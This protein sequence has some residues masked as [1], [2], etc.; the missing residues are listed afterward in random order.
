MA[1]SHAP[2]FQISARAETSHVIATKFQLWLPGCSRRFHRAFFIKSSIFQRNRRLY[3]SKKNCFVALRIL[4]FEKHFHLEVTQVMLNS[5]SMKISIQL[6]R[7]EIYKKKIMYVWFQINLKNNLKLSFRTAIVDA[8]KNK[9]YFHEI[10]NQN[11]RKNVSGTFALKPYYKFGCYTFL[12]SRERGCFC[13]ITSTF[14]TSPFTC[15][16]FRDRNR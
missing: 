4:A 8:P 2:Q 12:R 11:Q 9:H 16:F 7:D 5:S 3:I 10:I 15:G 1:F 6:S 13:N 14:V